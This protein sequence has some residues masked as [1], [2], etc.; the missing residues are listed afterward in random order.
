MYIMGAI[1]SILGGIFGIGCCIAAAIEN[2]GGC[3]SSSS[4]SART[5][6]EQDEIREN[7]RNNDY[8]Q[9]VFNNI[10]N[11]HIER[12]QNYYVPGY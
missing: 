2:N 1:E 8:N 11:D 9:R 4:S 7:I 6:R 12:M 5:H 10:Q 3:S